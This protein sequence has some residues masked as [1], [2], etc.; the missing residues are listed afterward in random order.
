MGW[1]TSKR[2][3][4]PPG[5]SSVRKTVIA[6]ALGQ[7]EQSLSPRDL[8][9]STIRCSY[10]GTEVDHIINLAAGGTD[11]LDNLQLLC[12]WHHNQKTQ[13]EASKNRVRRTERHPG[14]KH[15][16]LIE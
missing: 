5:W 2:R 14:E 4:D 12:H 6:R 10:P 15:P 1:E 3:K 16:G 8:P 9:Q 7:C 11:H 13:A